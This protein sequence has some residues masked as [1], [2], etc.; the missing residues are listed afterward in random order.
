MS[1]FRENRSRLSFTVKSDE[2]DLGLRECQAGACWAVQAHFTASDE[3]ALV[4]L[5]TGAGKT[6][7]MMLLA[8]ELQARRVLIITPTKVLREQTCQKFAELDGL[9]AAGIIDEEM[10][11][12]NT[13]EQTKRITDLAGWQDLQ[14]YDVVTAVPHAI[15]QVY[16]PEIVDPPSGLFDLVFFDEAHHLRAPS[17]DRLLHGFQDARRV[18]L[19]ATPFRRDRRRLPGKVA[20]YY[21][22]SRAIDAG[23]YQQVEY[24]PVFPPSS[25]VRDFFLVRQASQVLAQVREKASAAKILIRTDR[26]AESS[27]LVTLYEKANLQVE[28]VHSKRTEKQNSDTLGRLRK[29]ELDGVIG[30]GMLGEGLDIPHLKVAVFHVPPKSFPFTIQLIG[31]VSRTIGQDGVSAYVVADPNQLR[32]EGVEREVRRL[33]REDY[34]GW[35]KLIPDLVR[36][37][38]GTVLRDQAY[39]SSALLLG[40][41]LEDLR[42]FLSTRLYRASRDK[43]DL[44]AEVKLSDDYRVF[45]LPTPLDQPLLG[46]ITESLQSPPWATRTAIESSVFDLHLYY[47][48]EA[49]NTLFEATTSD[50]IAADIRPFILHEQ[51]ERLGG[52]E[53]IRTMQCNEGIDYIVAGLASTLGSSRAVPSY[54][55]YM[56]D[57]VQGAIT[58]SDVRAFV[59]GHL[60]GRLRM[61][62]EGETRG[63]S[64]KQGRV[65]STKRTSITEFA[66]WCQDIGRQLLKNQDV[67]APTDFAFFKETQRLSR[68]PQ[69]PLLVLMDPHAAVYQLELEVIDHPLPAIE[70]ERATFEVN[71]FVPRSRERI[72]VSMQLG[73]A[74]T[75]SVT[76]IEPINLVYDVAMDNW[77][78][79]ADRGYSVSVYDGMTLRR[80][81]MARFL[82]EFPPRMYL[83]DRGFIMGGRLYQSSSDFGPLP[84]DCVV[85][86]IDWADCEITVEYGLSPQAPR[87][88]VHTWLTNHLCDRARRDAVIFNDHG[89]REVADFILLDRE[90]KVV[91]FYHCKSA[92]TR[93]SGPRAGEPNIG[94]TIGHLKEVLDQVLRSTRWIGDSRLLDRIT[95][96]NERDIYPHFVQGEGVFGDLRASF[97]PI[98][99]DYEVYIVHPGLDVDEALET[100]NTN[101]LL[102]TCYEWLSASNASLQ[103]MGA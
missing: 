28:V 52:E 80:Y 60:F 2:A 91:Q 59:R 102:L 76:Q 87:K 86:D 29:G 22:L 98:E 40:A 16:H 36:R 17:W 94:A 89:S 93:S 77:S 100:R 26:I 54:K 34:D 48:H 12:P 11:G 21:P 95:D 19:T 69:L 73:Q 6:A 31:R 49:S 84:T 9:R 58:P 32:E 13:F 78:V 62:E 15:S 65:W 72:L 101:L 4:V 33:Y 1:Y 38:S 66:E 30:V 79:I 37:V 55:M 63:I 64:D 74:D 68:F 20:Y 85:R 42:P 75:F 88:D 92:S 25:S 50:A 47:Y 43:V 103:I 61:D 3:P 70:F 83:S 18:L 53:L 71:G 57:A 46:I 99:W 45:P 27:E 81:P 7:L 14:T 24:A 56:G 51:E 8:F 82:R 10:P 23:I 5:P 35:H 39:G 90:R 67:Q 41:D 44:G 97:R 96:R